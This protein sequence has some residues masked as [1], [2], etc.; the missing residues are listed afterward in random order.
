MCTGSEGHEGGDVSFQAY[1]DNI[2]A[3]T[4]RSPADFTRLAE[5]QGF[6]KQGT[7]LKSTKAGDVVKWLKEDFGL[8]HGHAMA[9]FAVF[10]GKKD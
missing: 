10:K 9:I 7:L 2:K 3:K 6:L 8:G 4:G 5:A 1:L